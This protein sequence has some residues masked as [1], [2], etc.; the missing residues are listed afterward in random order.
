M[1]VHPHLPGYRSFHV[2][3]NVAIRTGVYVGV[4][5]TLVFSAWLVIANRAPFLERF[6]L[7]RNIAAAAILGFLAAVPMFRFLRLPGHLL[8]SSLIGWLIFSFS[9]R[10]LCLLFRG[11]S[12][13]H[14]TPQVFMLGAVVYMI[15][16]TLSWIA[17]TIWRAREA[18]AS[19]PNHHAS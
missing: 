8:A 9:Y 6:A 10:V 12:N 2:F 14:S 18:H 13:W 11:L 1:L 7:E 16:T 17:T 5:L 4:C 15:L 3:R 19:H